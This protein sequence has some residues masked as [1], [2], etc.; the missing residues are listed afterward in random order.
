MRVWLREGVLM[1]LCVLLFTWVL[2]HE[3][4]CLPSFSFFV[5]ESKSGNNPATIA[6][7]PERKRRSASAGV[8]LATATLLGRQKPVHESS[9]S[10]EYHDSQDMCASVDCL[11]PG[12]ENV[13]D[14]VQCDACQLWYHAPC[15]LASSSSAIDRLKRSEFKCGC[16]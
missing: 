16:V 11:Q 12:K 10:E 2:L 3:Q 14:W 9:D 13:L 8:A 7:E 1:L 15:V 5:L 4:L 6:V